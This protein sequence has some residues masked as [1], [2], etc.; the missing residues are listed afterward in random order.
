MLPASIMALAEVRR[1][2]IGNADAGVFIF[3]AHDVMR[4]IGFQIRSEF[5]VK[6]LGSLVGSKFLRMATEI[7]DEAFVAE[8]VMFFGFEEFNML[9][10]SVPINEHGKV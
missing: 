1:T 9:R 3:G 4:V 2:P 5:F 6:N 8:D 7:G 10:A